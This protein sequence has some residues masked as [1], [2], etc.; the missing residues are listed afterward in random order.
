MNDPWPKELLIKARVTAI[1]GGKIPWWNF[2]DGKAEVC[3]TA[4]VIRGGSRVQS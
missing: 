2:R 4:P 1:L 3:E